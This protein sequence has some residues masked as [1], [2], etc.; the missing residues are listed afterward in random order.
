[1]M[2]NK[3]KENDRVNK[4]YKILASD[5]DGTLLGEGQ[6]VST[7]N[8]QAIE[9]MHSLGVE[10]VPATGRSLGEIP[11]EIMTSSFIRYIIT[12]D[13]AALW[14][15]A[16]EKMIITQYIPKDVVKFILDTVEPYT[17]YALVHEGGKTYY[18]EEINMSEIFEVCHVDDYFGS[19]IRERTHPKAAYYDFIMNSD[20]VEMFC[21]F[22]ESK[23]ALEKCR[24]IFLDSGKLSVA[25]SAPYNLEVCYSKAGKGNTLLTLAEALGVGQNEVIAVGDSTNDRSL[26][27][28]AGLGLAMENACDELKTIADKTIC[29][30]SE[31]SAKYIL[32]NFIS[33]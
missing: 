10:F 23:D 13:G 3:K 9:K 22:F 32:E 20:A 27:K 33:N 1:M 6:C 7:E 17:N 24:R 21:I 25:Q 11:H 29:K 18:N 8:L 31:H 14:D 30:Y 19:I 16:T 2:K 28:A 4:Q 12:S 5:L 15:K 26:I